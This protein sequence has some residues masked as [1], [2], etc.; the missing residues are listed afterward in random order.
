[1]MVEMGQS[2]SRLTED[3]CADLTAQAFPFT[4]VLGTPTH[5]RQSNHSPKICWQSYLGKSPVVVTAAAVFG[6]YPV[7][8]ILIVRPGLR[9]RDVKA[10]LG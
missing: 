5:S 2:V 9:L 6:R 1:M 10:D 7:L 3:A 4:I 8:V